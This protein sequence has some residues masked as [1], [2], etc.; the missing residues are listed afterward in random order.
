[1][2]QSIMIKIKYISPTNTKGARVKFV[3]FDFGDKPVS[4]TLSFNTQYSDIQSMALS[5][6]KDRY[7]TPLMVNSRSKETIIM[8]DWYNYAD[9]E[10]F[11]GLKSYESKVA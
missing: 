7:I 4:K 11:F 10:H 9:F 6:L 8:C 3:S 5:I 1:M 2:N